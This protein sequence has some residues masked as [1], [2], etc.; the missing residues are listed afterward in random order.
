MIENIKRR[1]SERAVERTVRADDLRCELASLSDEV[2][3]LA[4]ELGRIQREIIKR[5]AAYPSK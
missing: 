1:T 2:A 4:L 5:Q 3:A